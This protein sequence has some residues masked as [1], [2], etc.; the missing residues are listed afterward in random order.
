MIQTRRE[1]EIIQKVT[2]ESR[3]EI[4]VINEKLGELYPLKEEV[5]AQKKT[6]ERFSS[7]MMAQSTMISDYMTKSK[8]E[9]AKVEEKRL[10]TEA[11]MDD[12]KTYVDNFGEN[13][14]LSAAQITVSSS[15]GFAA[16][17]LSLHEIL[18]Q[19]HASMLETQTTMIAHGGQIQANE[20]MIKTKAD[21]SIVFEM[22][23]VSKKMEDVEKHVRKED[24][25]GVSVSDTESPHDLICFVW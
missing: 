22:E 6:I 19:V 8:K 15:A 24:E 1:I 17:P 10:E 11:K 16:K 5:K 12:L 21:E 7:D 25:Q 23:V 4:N 9:L 14:M 20:E 3:I 2:A 13:L 18:K